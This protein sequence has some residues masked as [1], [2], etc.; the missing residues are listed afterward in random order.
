M[1]SSY[2]SRQYLVH[3]PYS[4][5]FRMKVPKDLQQIVGRK[6][7]RYSLKTGYKSLAQSKARLFAGFFQWAFRHARGM[8]KQ[9]GEF[10]QQNF[11]DLVETF[12]KWISDDF[13]S[14]RLFQGSP[15]SAEDVRKNLA[16]AVSAYEETQ[17]ELIHQD[18]SEVSPML[19]NFI[20]GMNMEVDK[21]SIAYKQL[22]KNLLHAS[23]KLFKIDQKRI[24]GDYSDNI[25]DAIRQIVRT[26]PFSFPDE[27]EHL[28][29]LRAS[30]PKDKPSHIL[31]MERPPS[32]YDDVSTSKPISEVM[33][34]HLAECKIKKLK[35]RT[36]TEY[37]SVYDLFIRIM[38]N[39]P[40]KSVD[41]LKVVRGELKMY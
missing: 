9:M 23:L 15:V 13:E 34:K 11:E 12:M 33:E 36:I 25:E 22:C 30:L 8:K 20:E 28:G 24:K 41:R 3:N 2:R 10:S 27:R 19:D 37:R 5:C 35:P 1:K 39:V 16:H 6:E 17:A 32:V 29:S 38:G 18:F 31:N 21:N 7:L 4:Y 14:E 40:I 26:A